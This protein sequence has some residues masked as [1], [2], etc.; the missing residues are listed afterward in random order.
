[1]EEMIMKC[2]KS[3]RLAGLIMLIFALFLIQRPGFG[4]ED[5]GVLPSDQESVSEDGNKKPDAQ[6]PDQPLNAD[7]PEDTQSGA[8]TTAKATADAAADGTAAAG[9]NGFGDFFKNFVSIIQKV[10][11]LFAK[12]LGAL[13]GDGGDGGIAAGNNG[14]GNTDTGTNNTGTAGTGNNG[15]GNNDNETDTDNGTT[16]PGNGSVQQRVVQEANKLVG[17]PFD[18]DPATSGGRKACAQ[19]VT[20]ALKAAG[21]VGR[22]VLGVLQAIEDLKSKG[23]KEVT[24]PPFAGGDVITWKTYDRNGDGAKDPDTH[25]GIIMQSGNSVQAMSNSSSQLIP[26]LTSAAYAPISRVL[27]KV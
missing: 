5:D 27:R 10:F 26:R 15:A 2:R 24:V 25:I 13:F 1:M 3:L 23:W 9:G 21:V 11:D 20:T 4:L 18:Y 22:V 16:G 19:V 8:A 12:I 14:T 6:T 7:Q 17:K